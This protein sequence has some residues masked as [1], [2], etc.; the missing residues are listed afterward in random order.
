MN[1]G[2]N[3]DPSTGP[4]EPQAK[5]KAELSTLLRMPGLV[6]IG[7]YMFLLAGIVVV[8]VVERRIEPLFLVF[9]PLFFAAGLGL[10]ML[11]RW[12]WALTSAAVA[13]LAASFFW[14]CMTQHI[15][16]YLVHGLINLVF[17][18][19]LV[20]TEVRAKLR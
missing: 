2:A 19:Y 18:L 15:F 11:L 17:F 4:P 5:R 6:A 16:F 10:M 12:A 1:A 14:T 9:A 7:S 20:R 3:P 13:L 8:Y